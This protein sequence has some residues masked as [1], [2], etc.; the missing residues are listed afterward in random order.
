MIRRPPRSTLSPSSAASDVYKRQV[1]G[2]AAILGMPFALNI[3]GNSGMVPMMIL[4]S[5]PIFNAFSVVI[6]TVSANKY[7]GGQ[8]KALNLK[9]VLKLSLIHI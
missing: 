8:K 7:N 2:S 4:A 9:T 3:Y 5:V 1:R 6:L